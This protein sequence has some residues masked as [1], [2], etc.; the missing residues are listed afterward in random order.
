MF[1]RWRRL[2]RVGA[3]AI[4]S[5]VAVAVPA[6]PSAA[7]C[8]DSAWMACQ[9]DSLY[10]SQLSIPGTHDSGALWADDGIQ[11]IAAYQFTRAQTKNT[12]DQLNAGIRF[13]DIRFGS[14]S[15]TTNPRLRVYHGPCGMHIYA[16]RAGPIPSGW[17]SLMTDVTYFLALHPTETVILS[18]SDE[19]KSHP[20]AFEQLMSELVARTSSSLWWR[21]NWIPK[22]GE[23]R[24]KIVLVRRFAHNHLDIVG[25]DASVGWPDNTTG[26][27][28]NFVVED[29]YKGNSLTPEAKRTVVTNALNSA[30]ARQAAGDINMFVTFTSANGFN[31]SGYTIDQYSDVVN[32]YLNQRFP[33]AGRSGIV[34][35]DKV[36]DEARPD[37]V[38]R[39]IAANR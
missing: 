38:H 7:A 34:V 27:F 11:C 9:N 19:D 8:A 26:S 29:Q 2:A 3:A 23:A 18:V 13:L 25:M 1:G 12:F 15:W 14:E 24:G 17:Y 6:K 5:T 16:D 20:Y 21:N 10:V 31:N 33:S 35:M 4:I 22:L 39:V 37:L 30:H 36:M 32:E 28:R